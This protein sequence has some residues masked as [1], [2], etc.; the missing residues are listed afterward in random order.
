MGCTQS[1]ATGWLRISSAK[2]SGALSGLEE[3]RSCQLG[4]EARRGKGKGLGGRKTFDVRSRHA[5]ESYS[6]SNL[7]FLIPDLVGNVADSHQTRGAEAEGGE[8]ERQDQRRF[9]DE[10][11]R[12]EGLTG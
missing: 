3:G 5:L 1:L 8:R 10:T 9:G 12:G 11:R 7:D 4:R 2:A 6:E